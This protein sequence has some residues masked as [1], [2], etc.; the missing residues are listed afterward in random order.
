MENF[1][2]G[3]IE[4]IGNMAY[5]CE[6]TYHG[7]SQCALIALQDGLGLGD[8]MSFKAASALPS[9]LPRKRDLR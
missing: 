4:K 3:L 6:S 8:K 2:E 7:C 5:D 9:P 1:H